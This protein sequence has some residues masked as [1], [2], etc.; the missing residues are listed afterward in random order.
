MKVIF[1]TLLMV[2]FYQT[3]GASQ[4]NI[5]KRTVQDKF[6]NTRKYFV[7]NYY[8]INYMGQN[9]M[10]DV[11]QDQHG[12]MY[13][14]NNVGGVLEYDGIHWRTIPL[15]NNN[16]A[17]SMDMDKNGRVYVG[18]FGEIGYLTEKNGISSYKTL[19]DFVPQ[20]YRRFGPS[21]VK[22]IAEGA[23]F[24]T[25]DVILHWYNNAF[26]V[27]KNSNGKTFENIFAVN[28]EIYT[29]DENGNI[30]RIEGNKPVVIFKEQPELFGG[31][32][33][34]NDYNMPSVNLML[35]FDKNS[36]LIGSYFRGL[37]IFD[38]QRLDL[39][40]TEADE[41]LYGNLSYAGTAF[42]DN[43]FAIGTV[44]RG[45]VIVDKQ[46]KWRAWFDEN[47]GLI[48]NGIFSTYADSQN[49][50]WVGTSYG[51]SQILYPAPFFGYDSSS[52]IDG[53]VRMTASLGEKMY[54]VTSMGAYRSTS[55]SS[56]LGMQ[57]ERIQGINPA[58]TGVVKVF[59]NSIL[60]GSIFGLFQV[61][62]L[63]SA[64]TPGGEDITKFLPPGP[65]YSVR[66][67]SPLHDK[68][69][70]FIAVS[71]K[72]P[73][74]IYAA[75]V[76]EGLYIFLYKKGAWSQKGHLKIDDAIFFGQEDDEGILWITGV[77]SG[78]YRIDFSKGNFENP[79]IK[80]YYTAEGLL[81][82]YYAT[83]I[84]AD[85]VF[86]YSDEAFLKFD[87]DKK[88]FISDT[89][90]FDDL[91]PTGFISEAPDGNV[92]ITKGRPRR[93]SRAFRQKDSSYARRMSPYQRYNNYQIRNFGY[94]QNGNT[95]FGADKSL[96]NFEPGVPFSYANSYK[97]LI[98]KVSVHD[99][100]I[101]GPGC[102]DILANQKEN[103]VVRTKNNII[104]LN[105]NSN[106]LRFDFAGLFI[107]VEFSNHYQ[108]WLE[109]LSD[110]WTKWSDANYK[111]YNNLDPGKYVFHVKAK[112]LYEAMGEEALFEF[113]I[114]PPWWQTW[115]FYLT[116]IGL[117]ILLLLTSTLLNRTG[118]AS[119][120]AK[121]ITLV[122]I[123]IIF[124][125]LMLFIEPIAETFGGGIPI[126][127]LFLNVGLAMVF[128]PSQRFMGEIL[129]AKRRQRKYKIVFD[130]AGNWSGG[131]QIIPALRDMRKLKSW[132][133]AFQRE[134]AD[135]GRKYGRFE[136]NQ[137][138]L[139]TAE[140]NDLLAEM[141]DLLGGLLIFRRYITKDRPDHFWATGKA[142][143]HPYNI[144]IFPKYWKGEGSVR[145][146]FEFDP[147]KFV[148]WYQD[149]IKEILSMLEA[150]KNAMG[151]NVLTDEERNILIPRIEKIFHGVL[152]VMN[153]IGDKGK[154]AY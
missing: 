48:N 115:W 133:E 84:V 79:E 107:D 88:M 138:A 35:P 136:I 36:I 31:Y 60:I 55:A 57:F 44:D 15:A 38:G 147:L 99:K 46:G 5:L 111:E 94:D 73:G 39:F 108:V 72:H 20:P 4:T 132:I 144:K 18:G 143:I 93:L 102:E 95:W 142:D 152:V 32:I 22:C 34:K 135:I 41:L 96:L 145:A 76:S 69:C 82:G 74:I 123:V 68:D 104:H 3:G 33:F 63:E 87:R 24:K 127:Q 121:I 134:F 30:F 153:S 42:A 113:T 131:A 85:N 13:F 100:P 59:G 12:V 19:M 119:R 146:D 2:L 49:C 109:G 16:T 53:Q 75:A 116:E 140:K 40:Q 101:F 28:N 10:Y 151:D 150:Y 154:G 86:M 91:L 65:D 149:L 64:L 29:S 54:V 128:E 71:K 78:G 23:Y 1:V 117:L 103:P 118:K 70:R 110:H 120:F 141:E 25:G 45:V 90:F 6:P 77:N 97:T 11:I 8:P 137:W 81:E 52:G 66:S 27:I 139:S 89:T 56:E 26:S 21:Q 148:D 124:E 14:G 80:N 47:N 106:S 98:R 62:S 51:F 129:V 61:E 9:Q 50:L 92:W 67:F 126:A 105:Y 7:K 43:Y 83:S 130:R 122:T 114:L 112:N 58:E 37:L 17:Y 125:S